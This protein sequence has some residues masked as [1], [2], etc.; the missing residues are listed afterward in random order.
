M[1]V[2]AKYRVLTTAIQSMEHG[3][4]ALAHCWTLA[5]AFDPATLSA[6]DRE[7]VD[8]LKGQLL[9]AMEETLAAKSAI[10]AERR[11]R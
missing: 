9:I 6:V 10:L 1:T 7:R 3:Y 5:R 2:S 8:A 11:A 4:T